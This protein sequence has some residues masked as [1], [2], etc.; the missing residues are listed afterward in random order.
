M[1]DSPVDLSGGFAFRN[2][3]FAAAAIA[4]TAVAASSW[5]DRWT[6]A[7]AVESAALRDDMSRRMANLPRPREG[8]VASRTWFDRSDRAP[9][10]TV[11]TKSPF[12]N[13]VDDPSVGMPQ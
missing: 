5:L 12:K 8:A 10:A 11:K 7:A 13:F 1:S 6:K 2:Y 4:L 9:V 3:A